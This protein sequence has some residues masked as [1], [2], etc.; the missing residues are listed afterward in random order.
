MDS[1]NRESGIPLILNHFERPIADPTHPKTAEIDWTP[2]SK[3]TDKLW[4]CLEVMRDIDHL[5]EG[6]EEMRSSSS[7]AR[8]IKLL[9]TPLYSFCQCTRSLSC[10][11]ETAE[12]LRERIPAKE[13]AD[14]TR[15]RHAFERSVPMAQLAPLRSVRDKLG[16]HM[17]D[18]V[19]PHSARAL[20]D[21]ATIGHCGAWLHQTLILLIHLLDVDVYGW[22]TADAG[23]DEVRLMTC[24]PFLVTLA[25]EN[26]KAKRIVGVEATKSPR[27]EIG[28]MCQQI[29]ARSQWMFRSDSR[30]DTEQEPVHVEDTTRKDPAD[31]RDDGEKQT[32]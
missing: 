28:Q 14:I 15:R 9:A 10:F 22:S 32:T 6:T 16:A 11:L 26:G 21:A 5:L 29:V 4:R 24:E 19:V 18:D 3:A 23:P 31:I 25:I 1:D 30:A 12:E 17:D 2:A 13:R 27:F 7:R 8:R 20:L